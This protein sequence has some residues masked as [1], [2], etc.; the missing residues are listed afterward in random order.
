MVAAAS[1]ARRWKKA[2]ADQVATTSFDER[3][4]AFRKRLLE[5]QDC[6]PASVAAPSWAP[7][8]AGR[9]DFSGMQEELAV[10]CSTSFSF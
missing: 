1:G 3:K 6:A 5:Q 4:E 8:G 9:F 7:A 2:D 10:A